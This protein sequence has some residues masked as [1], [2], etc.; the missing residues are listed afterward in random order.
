MK[1]ATKEIFNAYRVLADMLLSD[2]Y[3]EAGEFLSLWFNFDRDYAQRCKFLKL[4]NKS[5]NTDKYLKD[6][7]LWK[8]YY[9]TPY[10]GQTAKTCLFFSDWS[11]APHFKGFNDPITDHYHLNDLA[12]KLGYPTFKYLGE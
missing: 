8:I 7:A 1:E 10:C 9:Y 4:Y 5:S 6:N 2:G 3:T 11:K 12:N